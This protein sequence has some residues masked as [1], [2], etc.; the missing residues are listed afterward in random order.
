LLRWLDPDHLVFSRA[1]VLVG[2]AAL[3]V[4]RRRG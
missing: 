3:P 1:V 2:G 4:M